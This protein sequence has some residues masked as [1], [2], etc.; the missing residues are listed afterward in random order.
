MRHLLSSR[1]VRCAILASFSIGIL[2][3]CGE[4]GPLQ[5]SLKLSQAQSGDN[6]SIA[7][8]VDGAREA[9]YSEVEY[10]AMNDL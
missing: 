6:R 8:T 3:S 10:K 9:M 2:T 7:N 5:L 4:P 1:V